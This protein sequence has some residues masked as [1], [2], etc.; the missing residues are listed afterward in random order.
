MNDK[1]RPS[2]LSRLLNLLGSDKDPEFDKN[3]RHAGDRDGA[4]TISEEPTAEE[5]ERVITDKF[6][7]HKDD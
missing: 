3:L 6:D 4:L 7:P 5:V 2:I 1:K